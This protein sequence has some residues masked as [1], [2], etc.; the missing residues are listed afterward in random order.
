[1]IINKRE[2]CDLELLLNGSFSPLNHFMNKE[3][4]ESVCKNM[5]LLTGEVFP[6][7][8]TLTIDEKFK[9]NKIITLTDETLYPLATLHVEEVYKPNLEMECKYAYGTNDTNHPYVAYKMNQNK[10]YVSG[11]VEQINPP[12]HYDFT[13]HRKRLNEYRKKIK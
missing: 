11:K 1:M 7:P 8:I 2:Q 5:R 13:E 3:E 12:N 4:V 10:L 6:L 9:N